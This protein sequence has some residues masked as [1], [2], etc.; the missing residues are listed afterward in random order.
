[1]LIQLEAVAHDQDSYAVKECLRTS[2]GSTASA[3]FSRNLF[4]SIR[5][6]PRDHVNWFAT[7][8]RVLL[9]TFAIRTFAY[10]LDMFTDLILLFDYYRGV[11]VQL[12]LT[13]E[14]TVICLLIDFPC[15]SKAY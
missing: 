11:V 9:L 10:G 13:L 5:H 1:M 2:L 14:F 3:E 7:F 4:K 15:L 6:K 8:L 12:N